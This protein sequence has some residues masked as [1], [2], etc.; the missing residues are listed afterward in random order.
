[1]SLPQI[2]GLELQEL[3]GRGSCGAVYRA[4][5]MDGGAPCAVKVFSSMAINRKLMAIG[6]RGLQQMP[7]HPGLLRPVAFDFDNSPYFCATPL[8]GSPVDDGR[9][10]GSWDSPTLE[11]HCGNVPADEAW[12]YIYEI[13]DSMAWLHR[14]NLVHCNLKP[15]NVL[16]ESDQA[17]TD[18]QPDCR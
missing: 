1:M 10:V 3:I 8:V 15:R 13:C 6:M 5:K 17:I 4:L 9:G 2:A 7:P 12:R 14:H 18:T 11:N 16:V